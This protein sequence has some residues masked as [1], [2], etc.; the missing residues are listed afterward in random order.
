MNF[1][2]LATHSVTKDKWWM[3]E[4][5]KPAIVTTAKVHLSE[6]AKNQGKVRFFNERI[7]IL[8]M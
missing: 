3:A 4:L 5:K 2:Q 6:W 7:R 8:H 1:L